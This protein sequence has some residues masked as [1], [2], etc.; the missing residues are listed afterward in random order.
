MTSIPRSRH[1]KPAS[2]SSVRT[3][4][5]TY[6]R[7]FGDWKAGVFVVASF[8]TTSLRNEYSIQGISGIKWQDNLNTNN[9]FR[10]GFKAGVWY[11]DIGVSVAYNPVIGKNSGQVPMYNSMQ[12][13]IS[14]RY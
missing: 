2:T 9:G 5:T 6:I 12:I 10:L 8:G 7:E 4:S 1:P 13:G 3:I 14:V 11:Q